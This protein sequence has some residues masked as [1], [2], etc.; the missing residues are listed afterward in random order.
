MNSIIIKRRK[1][2][3]PASTFLETR[4]EKKNCMTSMSIKYLEHWM[5]KEY[6][7][8]Q[9]L[10]KDHVDT[11]FLELTKLE[12]RHGSINSMR[13]SLQRYFCWLSEQGF[14]KQSPKDVFI[15][16][17]NGR[18]VRNII[19]PAEAQRY[20]KVMSVQ[21]KPNSI[22]G[23][24]ISLKT[25]YD[26]LQSNKLSIENV[27]KEDMDNYLISLS[28]EKLA[29]NTRRT[30]LILLKSYLHWLYDSEV[31]KINADNLLRYSDIPKSEKRLPRPLAHEVDREIQRRLSESPNILHKGLL[32]MRRTGIRIG[33]L[34]ALKQDCLKTDINGHSFLK[35]ELGKLYT[36]RMVP[37]HEDTVILIKSIQEEV[38][39]YIDSP[40]KL[41][42]LSDGRMPPSSNFM[43]ALNDIT[44]G[45]KTKKPIVSHQFRHSFACE[46]LNC[47]MSLV[48]L[49]EILGHKDIKM[50]LQYATVTQGTIRESFIKAYGM[51]SKQYE[52]PTITTE[53]KFCPEKSLDGIINYLKKIA[54]INTS[55]QQKLTLINRRLFRIKSE[56]ADIR[57]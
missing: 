20:L 11:F 57:E 14:V 32:V 31:I 4:K 54:S 21:V 33:E 16:M 3:E 49:K 6:V 56:L 2:S 35:V 51:I 17:V 10:N 41:V 44:Y 25:F 7:T 48:V 27:N 38:L 13:I 19:L 34:S 18:K 9:S 39:G 1:L 40:E 52:L 46:M 42:H 15:R 12:L 43:Y 26:Y 37:L 24:K 22:G 30:S 8:I 28:K 50:T 29:N 55:E 47:G 5:E 23:Y 53:T 45:F 36:E